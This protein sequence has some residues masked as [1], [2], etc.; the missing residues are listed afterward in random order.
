MGNEISAIS[1]FSI[2]SNDDQCAKIA[3]VRNVF[4]DVDVEYRATIIRASSMGALL[5]S[6][7][8]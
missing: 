4:T 7:T 6:S 1:D 5:I 2:D 3:C 8:T